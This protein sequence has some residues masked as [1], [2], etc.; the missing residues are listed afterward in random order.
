MRLIQE[1]EYAAAPDLAIEQEGQLLLFEALRSYSTFTIDPV[2]QQV[3][4]PALGVGDKLLLLG[5]AGVGKSSVFES[6]L[7]S[8][9]HNAFRE[10]A[11]Q[12]AV[13]LVETYREGKLW[14]MVAHQ[15][16]ALNDTVSEA[17]EELANVVESERT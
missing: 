12:R 5:Q 13:D 11:A 9:L 6:E 4:H 16:S 10:I 3:V 15:L 14:E 8:K 17:R 2:L 1:A 7:I